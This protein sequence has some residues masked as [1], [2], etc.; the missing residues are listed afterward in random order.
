MKFNPDA[1]EKLEA[2]KAALYEAQAFVSDDAQY[3][4]INDIMLAIDELLE[5]A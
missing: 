2:A 3:G 5:G 1:V 4:A